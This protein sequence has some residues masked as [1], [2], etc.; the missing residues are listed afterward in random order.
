[1]KL[2]FCIISLVSM[3]RKGLVT[4]FCNWSISIFLKFFRII[5]FDQYPELTF[6]LI[7]AVILCPVGLFILSLPFSTT[8]SSNIQRA[9]PNGKCAWERQ[10]RCKT[11]SLYSSICKAEYT[12]PLSIHQ[13]LKPCMGKLGNIV[14][15]TLFPVD[16]LSCFPVWAN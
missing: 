14:A 15:E 7:S 4:K 12:R 13:K 16:V 8:L 2:S 9:N 11:I 5:K 10:G 1:M 6:F 3:L